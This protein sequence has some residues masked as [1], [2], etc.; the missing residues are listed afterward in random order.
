MVLEQ[1]QVVTIDDTDQAIQEYLR[2][3][4]TQKEG[5][6]P[7]DTG[8]KNFVIEKIRMS[9]IQYGQPLVTEFILNNNTGK[10]IKNLRVGIQVFNSQLAR[11]L[12]STMEVPSVPTGKQK[13]EIIA[14]NTNLP[15]G[16]YN[17]GIG[18]GLLDAG[19]FYKPQLIFFEIQPS[20]K[21]DPFVVSRRDVLGVCPPTTYKMTELS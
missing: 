14:E 15:P 17:V 8:V 1:G 5:T 10:E 21:I 13:M 9:Q 18:M 11:V 12:T 6:G 7:F 3:A 4:N 20:G 16:N 2:L 19:I